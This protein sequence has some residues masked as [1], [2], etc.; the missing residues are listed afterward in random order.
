MALAVLATKTCAVG[1]YLKALNVEAEHR[2]VLG[3]LGAEL[4]GDDDVSAGFRGP[5]G[6]WCRGGP[7]QLDN[8]IAR[9]GATEAG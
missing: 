7:A 3:L 6:L 2:A 5:L 9:R 1:M 8:D 4:I